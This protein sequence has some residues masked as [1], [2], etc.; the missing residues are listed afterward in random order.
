MASAGLT[1]APAKD[2]IGFTLTRSSI[3]GFNKG[4]VAP[5]DW[6]ADMHPGVGLLKLLLDNEAAEVRGGCA[7]V[8]HA[9][10]ACM[11][12]S[13]TDVLELPSRCPYPLRLE[14]QGAIS[15]LVFRI[16]TLWLD[17]DGNAQPGFKRCGVLL[18]SPAERFLLAEPI[19]SASRRWRR[20]TPW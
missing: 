4:Q 15:D 14:A 5:A 1:F 7:W 10:I 20:S 17:G 3:L 11:P 16:E 6:P 19:F 18:E 2:G 12:Q 9:T 13:E 8:S